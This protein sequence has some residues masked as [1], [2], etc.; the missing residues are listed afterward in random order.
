MSPEIV[1]SYQEKFF[2]Y[3]EKGYTKEIERIETLMASWYLPHFA[4][5]KPD[6]TTTKT[7]IVLTLQQNV[8]EFH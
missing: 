2:K 1:K 5:T 8:T 4:I 3:L 7:R 6:G